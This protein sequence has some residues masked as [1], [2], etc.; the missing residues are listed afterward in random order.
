MEASLFDSA[1]EFRLLLLLFKLSRFTRSLFFGFLNR[2]FLRTLGLFGGTFLAFGSDVRFFFGLD[3]LRLLQDVLR[4]KLALPLVAAQVL[5]AVFAYHQR[6]VLGVERVYVALKRGFLLLSESPVA[7]QHVLRHWG[8]VASADVVP[9]LPYADETP[10][11]I[12]FETL[13][14]HRVLSMRRFVVRVTGRRILGVRQDVLLEQQFASCCVSDASQVAQ[15]SY[16][17]GITGPEMENV[18]R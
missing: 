8:T 9:E 5:C 3:T 4:V 7:L 13:L 1:H 17:N 18:S 6:L 14:R 2:L 11:Q 10:A 16:G 12:R 15:T